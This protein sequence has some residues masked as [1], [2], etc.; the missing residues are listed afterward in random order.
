MQPWSS[1]RPAVALPNTTRLT[2]AGSTPASAR[3]SATT[4]WAMSSAVRSRRFMGVMAVP[5]MCAVRSMVSSLSSS[6]VG[7]P[8]GRQ[9]GHQ[10]LELFERLVCR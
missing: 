1:S 7:T 6:S 10:A 9:G 5:T 3:A 2:S 8:A 4:W